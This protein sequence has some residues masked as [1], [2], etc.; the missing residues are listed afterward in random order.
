MNTEITELMDDLRVLRIAAHSVVEW[1]R[2]VRLQPDQEI[3]WKFISSTART[4]CFATTTRCHLLV[5]VMGA[6]WRPFAA[7]SGRC[8]A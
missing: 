8:S 5:T 3:L 4:S 2:S 7:S 6:R 1:A